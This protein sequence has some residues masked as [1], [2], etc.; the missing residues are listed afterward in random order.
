MNVEQQMFTS[1]K[2]EFV[3]VAITDGLSR[4]ERIA[5]EQHSLYLLPTALMYQD[6]VITPVKYV[7]YPLNSKRGVVGKAVYA[8]KDSMGRPGNYFFHNLVF[9]YD[10]LQREFD[11]N[12]AALIRAIEQ[13]GLFRTTA[14]Q[15][16][17]T[18]LEIAPPS[19]LPKMTVPPINQAGLEQLLYIGLNHQSVQLPLLLYGTDRECL[20]LLERLYPLLPYQQRRELSFDTY[21]YGTGL[22]FRIQGLPEQPEFR[23]SLSPALTLACAAMQSN[24]AFQM[25][26]PSKRLE[27]IRGLVFAGKLRD[28]N[29]VYALEALSDAAN[30]VEFTSRFGQVS[31]EIQR[32]LY[33]FHAPRLLAHLIEQ[34]NATLLDQLQPYLTADDLTVLSAAPDMMRRYAEQADNRRVDIFAEWV[35]KRTGELAANHALLFEFPRLWNALLARIAVVPQEAAALLL[36]LALF[37]KYYSPEY[38]AALFGLLLGILPQIKPQKD[39][40]KAFLPL[41]ETFPRPSSQALTLLRDAVM[42]ELTKNNVLFERLLDSDVS[43]LAEEKRGAAMRVILAGI[44]GMSKPKEK[45]AQLTTVVQKAVKQAGMLL[46]VLQALNPND[47]GKPERTLLQEL[48][49]T[50]PSAQKSPQIL[51]EIERVLQPPSSFFQRISETFGWSR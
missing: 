48:F 49:E 3:T 37:P 21:A 25:P 17:L 29:T 50:V 39:F 1:G 46:I 19:R 9:G 18:P 14:P 24:A 33:D 7:F 43:V 51:A 23:Q 6:G 27:M 35:C 4:E 8:G 32:I 36:P 40:V 34:R 28:L 30:F 13:Q 2:P 38:D 44:F 11:L 16:K 5:L 47:I 41:V 45:Q 10:D 22:S 31:A 42:F 12:P 26:E 15:D 20:D